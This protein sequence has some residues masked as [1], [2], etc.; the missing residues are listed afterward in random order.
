MGLEPTKTKKGEGIEM[1]HYQITVDAQLLHQLFLRD[2][3]DDAF[4]RLLESVLNQ[5]LKV[6]AT[7]QLRAEPYERTEERQGYRNGTYPHQLTTRVGT[8]TLRVPRFRN[9]KFSTE[10]FARYQRSEQALVLVLME[11]VV[12][13]F[14]DV[15]VGM[16][17]YGHYWLKVFHQLVA[18]CTRPHSSAKSTCGTAGMTKCSSLIS[19][20]RNNQ[21][22]LSVLFGRRECA[23]APSVSS[24]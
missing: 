9:G 14:V 4:V 16:E 15:V 11:S 1:A 17:P 6:Q 19:L 8:L 3:K 7:V 10:R 24:V 21:R 12:R 2:T 23:Q 18:G 20:E 13:G 5:I 22:V